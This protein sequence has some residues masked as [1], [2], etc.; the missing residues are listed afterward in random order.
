[1]ERK[2]IADLSKGAG[3]PKVGGA[4]DLLDHEGRAF[5]DGDMKG[6]FS[7]VSASHGSKSVT[8]AFISAARHLLYQKDSRLCSRGR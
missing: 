3:R 6:G 8:A 1:M 2:R 5:G 4:F 7:L